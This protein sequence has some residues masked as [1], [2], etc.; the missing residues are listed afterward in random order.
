VFLNSTSGGIALFT[1]TRVAYTTDNQSINKRII[2]E[3]F[4]AEK[5]TALTLGD[6]IKTVKNTT[7]IS[8]RKIGYSLI[9]DPALRLYYPEQNAAIH[10]I[11][12][13]ETVKNDTIQIAA[14]EVSLTGSITDHSGNIDTG[15]NGK[16]DIIMFDNKGNYETLG[17][18]TAIINSTEII[19]LL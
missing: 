15:Y 17:N 3:I 11:N 4:S 9:G 12:G 13:K 19:R 5:N 14:P 6:I 1:T 18:N 2:E 7:T 10:S 8:N 16:V